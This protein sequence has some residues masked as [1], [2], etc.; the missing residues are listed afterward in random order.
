MGDGEGCMGDGE[1][2]GG[3][4][5]RPARPALGVSLGGSHT[6]LGCS[7]SEGREQVSPQHYPD[8][9]WTCLP[10]LITS[11]PPGLTWCWWPWEAL[12]IPHVDARSDVVPGKRGSR[13][14][15]LVLGRCLRCT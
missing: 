7:V 12:G 6:A 8:A 2:S 14:I 10:D 1:G 15:W 4:G 13:Q 3:L 11:S 5:K 9:S